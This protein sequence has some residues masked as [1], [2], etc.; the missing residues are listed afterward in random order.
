MPCSRELVRFAA[1]RI[2]LP[3]ILSCLMSRYSLV[4]Q[5]HIVISALVRAWQLSY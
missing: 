1:T 3:I 5:V 2:R 4:E